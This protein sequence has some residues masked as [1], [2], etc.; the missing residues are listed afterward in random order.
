MLFQSC[1]STKASPS[2]YLLSNTQYM[3]TPFVT[4]PHFAFVRSVASMDPT[5]ACQTRRLKNMSATGL[6][7]RHGLG[8]YI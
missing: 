8:P 7:R 5:M 3:Y 1:L 2:Q 6:E 4:V